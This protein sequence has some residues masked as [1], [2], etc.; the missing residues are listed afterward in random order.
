MFRR[1]PPIPQF[2]LGTR[3]ALA[4]DLP[5]KPAGTT[6]TVRGI[7]PTPAGLTYAVRFEKEMCIVTEA[8]L[9]AA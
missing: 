8:D 5:S 6:G 3:V 4:R 2:T 7:S 9:K 1:L